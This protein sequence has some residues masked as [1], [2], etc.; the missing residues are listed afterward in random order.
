MD[1]PRRR[2]RDRPICLTRPAR[3]AA[4]RRS[5]RLPS[6]LVAFSGTS[7]LAI[8]IG[9]AR[10]R[11]RQSRTHAR[12]R[13]WGAGLQSWRGDRGLRNTLTEI[14]DQ[15]V[16]DELEADQEDAVNLPLAIG[17]SRLTE[18]KSV[19]THTYAIVLPLSREWRRSVASA[20]GS[21]SG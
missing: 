7:E 10:Q 18:D 1:P 4:E 8:W 13:R 14:Q 9:A 6:A 11:R 2:A 16:I 17:C 3:L 19:D 21:E 12:T 20:V 15:D 5:L